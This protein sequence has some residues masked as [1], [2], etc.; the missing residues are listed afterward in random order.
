[1]NRFI[2]NKNFYQRNEIRSWTAR[3]Y[4]RSTRRQT[5]WTFFNHRP[6]WLGKFRGWILTRLDIHGWIPASIIETDPFDVRHL[7][8]GS[9]K[10]TAAIIT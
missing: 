2:A 8:L 1:M 10:L 3:T 5:A 6:R 9:I 7:N 4:I